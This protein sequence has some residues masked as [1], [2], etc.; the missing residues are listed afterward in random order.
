MTKRDFFRII[1]KLFG[2]YSLILT[3]FNFIPS[4]IWYITVEFEPIDIL[5]IFG[6]SAAVISIYVFLILKTDLIINLLK[7]DQGFDDEQILIGNFNSLSIF[8]FALIV[9]G[10]FLIVEYLPN[11]LQY[12]YLAFKSRVSSKGLHYL[13]ESTFGKQIDYFNWAVAGINIVFGIILL[14]NYEQI[15]KW[16]TRKEKR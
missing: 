6:V 2:L 14:T 1:I 16:L 11:F 10:G 8:K 15:A 9:I 3:I 13:E 5:W 4:N 7:I 12:T